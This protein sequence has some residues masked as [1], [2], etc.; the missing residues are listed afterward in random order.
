MAVLVMLYKVISRSGYI[1]F[2]Y[3]PHLYLGNFEGHGQR[4]IQVITGLPRKKSQ[5]HFLKNPLSEV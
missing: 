1:F 4:Q 5:T 2:K 3:D